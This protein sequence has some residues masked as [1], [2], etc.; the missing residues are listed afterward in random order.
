MI[1][2]AEMMWIL[3]IYGPLVIAGSLITTDLKLLE[4]WNAR[5]AE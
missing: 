5:A 3:W 1:A 4:S 2:G